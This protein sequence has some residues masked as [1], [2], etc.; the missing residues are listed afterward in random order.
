MRFNPTWTV[1]P[2]DELVSWDETP[3]ASRCD[4]AYVHSNDLATAGRVQRCV[5]ALG[6][7]DRHWTDEK[8]WF[9]DHRSTTVYTHPDPSEIRPKAK[10]RAAMIVFGE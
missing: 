1:K 3:G 4:K 8:T 9:G 7:T 6:H 10:S 2:E 5:L